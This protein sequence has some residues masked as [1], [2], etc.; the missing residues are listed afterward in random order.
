MNNDNNKDTNVNIFAH[1]LIRKKKQLF[2]I[3]DKSISSLS[4]MESK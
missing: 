4:Y 2:E 1:L 3:R